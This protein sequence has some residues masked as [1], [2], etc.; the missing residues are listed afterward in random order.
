MTRRVILS[1]RLPRVFQVLTEC[2]GQTKMITCRKDKLRE[3]I[4]VHR[5]RPLPGA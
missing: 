1:P 2:P 5:P 3:I 4:R